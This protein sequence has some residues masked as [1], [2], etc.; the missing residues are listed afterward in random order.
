M[1]LE[2]LV[3]DSSGMRLLEILIPQLLGPNG[4]PHTWRLHPYKGVGRIPKGLKP[5][6][7]APKRILLD[8][9]PRLLRG[10]AKNPHVDKVVVVVDSDSRPCADFLSEL[11]HAARECG[12]ADKTLF[13]LA[14]EEVEAWYFGDQAAI[15]AAYPKAK[16]SVLTKY[17]QDS[18]CG[19]W[20]MLADAIHP[21]GSKAIIGWTAV[22]QIK[23][24]WATKIGPFMKLDQNHSP[25]FKKFRDG[26]LTILIENN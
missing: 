7:D 16:V 14:I 11:K 22:G 10:F 17:V 21:K 1:H 9:L 8:Q 4:F 6:S 5:K 15:K 12:A 18:V 20:E 3:E 25:S 24:E 26:I 2:I 19:T 13:R 23:H